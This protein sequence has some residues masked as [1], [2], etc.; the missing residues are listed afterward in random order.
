L[1]LVTSEWRW[2]IEVKFLS[3]F[4]KIERG[5]PAVEYGLIAGAMGLAL[6]AVTPILADSLAIAFAR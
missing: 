4:V 1:A 3:R 5:A 2:S 6:L